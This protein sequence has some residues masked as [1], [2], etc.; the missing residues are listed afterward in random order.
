MYRR[1]VL[2]AWFV[3]LG[4]GTLAVV[5]AQPR[6]RPNSGPP[7]MEQ[8]AFGPGRS[9]F[10]VFSVGPPEA[11]EPVVGAPFSAETLTEITQDLADGNRV[12]HSTTGFVARDS[13]GR[14]RR[15]FAVPPIGPFGFDANERVVTILDPVSRV[16]YLLDGNRK[17]AV[18]T[19]LPP[20][21]VRGRRPPPSG[22]ERPP[23]ARADVAP[24]IRSDQ[25]PARTIEGLAVEGTRTTLIIPSGARG[26]VRPIEI[27]SEQWY[28]PDLHV[29]VSSRRADPL[30]GTV[31]YR[32]KGIN[33]AEPS[34]DLFQVPSDYRVM[35]GPVRPPMR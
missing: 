19:P 17:S 30:A 10:E 4:G 9:G 8:P 14:L 11:G 28:S 2:V 22:I 29:V 21:G 15:E 23:F 31:E 12:E 13:K 35:D 34:A 32:L 18:R 20:D 5:E 27:V 26:N 33:R 24:E 7:G 25:L 1:Q 16:L 6:P 3:L